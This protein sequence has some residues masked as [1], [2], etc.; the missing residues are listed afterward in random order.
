[1]TA[2]IEKVLPTPP[3]QDAIQVLEGILE[4]L[5]SGES[6][7]IAYV[8]VR[9]M[10]SVATGWADHPTGRYHFLCSGAAR[11]LSR[12]AEVSD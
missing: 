12:L 3:N 8:E 5:R 6:L 10:G 11:L 1:M 4:R 9:Q 7:A 2:K